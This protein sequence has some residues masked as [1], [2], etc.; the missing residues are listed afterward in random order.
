M[1]YCKIC[2]Q[3]NYRPN[4]R[5]SKNGI[6]PA[7]VYYDLIKNEDWNLRFKLLKN[8]ISKYKSKKNEFNCI[9]G[10]SGGKDST[11]QALWVRDKLGLKPLLACLTYPPEQISIRGTNNI[12]NLINLG[13]DV[14]TF[15]PGPLTWQR[16]MKFSF[17]NFS[18]WAKSTELALFSFVPQL[19]IRYQIP[20]IFWGENPGLQL[21]DLKTKSKFGY[22][23]KNLRYLNTLDG[24][25]LDWVSKKIINNNNLF[26]YKYPSVDEFKKNN[27]KII[28]L[29]WFLGDWSLKNNAYNSIVN[30]L[31]IR[32]SKYK[33]YGDLY[34]ITSLDEDW[35]TI[36][37][38]IKYY[39]YGFGRATDYVNEDIRAG[40]LTR[41]EGIK[42]VKKYDGKFSNKLIKSFCNYINITPLK[43]WDVVK[44][45]FNKELFF[46]KNNKI[47]PK[48]KVG[49][50]F[51]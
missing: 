51:K 26:P 37:Q 30:G 18:N 50:D 41:E 46:I 25:K 28:Y 4:T 3:N 32:E 34:R 8:I 22:D 45:S 15:S 33:N 39:K 16:L 42:I 21:G 48:F 40:N 19:A 31:E 24:G 2:L 1:K 27:I 36:N 13:F 43:F 44:N 23:G 47:T 7:C 17:L 14:V 11:R 20:L 10:V 38:L 12:S 6:C 49:E 5:F 29:G 35:V 9:V